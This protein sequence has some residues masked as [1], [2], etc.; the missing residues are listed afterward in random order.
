MIELCCWRDSGNL[1]ESAIVVGV[2]VLGRASWSPLHKVRF[3]FGMHWYTYSALNGLNP[4]YGCSLVQSIP[5]SSSDL[6]H[7]VY[8]VWY[9]VP[10]P[11]LPL[12]CERHTSG[13][14]GCQ[15]LGPA[16]MSMSSFHMWRHVV[17][18]VTRWFHFRLQRGRGLWFQ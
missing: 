6:V 13:T 2:S 15:L 1:L 4:C 18:A 9:F 10:L 17:V 7:S 16:C 11:V 14:L 12:H 3:W 5:Y 8:P